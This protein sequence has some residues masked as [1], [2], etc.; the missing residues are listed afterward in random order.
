MTERRLFSLEEA[1]A[2]IPVLRPLLERL[3]DMVNEAQRQQTEIQRMESVWPHANG[4]RV[5][6]EVNLKT[7]RATLEAL[8]T[9][10]RTGISEAEAH[11]CEVKDP[12]TG[13]IDFRSPR[14]GRVVYLCWRLGEDDIAFW[15]TLE[16]GFKGRQ[17]Q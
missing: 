12:S 8:T 9:D 11:G 15:H 5:E 7:A 6:L 4:H 13:L 1:N 17:P 3:R 16:D 10:I 14:D 2:L